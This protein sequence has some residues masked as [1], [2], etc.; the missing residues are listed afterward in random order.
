MNFS[1]FEIENIIAFIPTEIKDA[2]E[3]YKTSSSDN[4]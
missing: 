4:K 3:E 1:D 2:I